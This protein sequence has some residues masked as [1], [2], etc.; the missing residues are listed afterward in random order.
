ML[1]TDGFKRADKLERQP[2]MHGDRSSVAA[3]SDDREHLAPRTRAAA[4]D[5][6]SQ[7]GGADPTAVVRIGDVDRIFERKPICRTRTIGGGVAVARYGAFD[8]GD[9]I[10]NAIPSTVLRR[11]SISSSVGGVSSKEARPCRTLCA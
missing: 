5:E 3:V 11:A 1:E 2:A 9:E 10:G 7:Q 4:V 8:L 6:R